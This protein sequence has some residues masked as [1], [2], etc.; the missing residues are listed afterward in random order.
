MKASFKHLFY[1][2]FGRTEFAPFWEFL[3]KTSLR[4]LNYGYCDSPSKS[5]E[6]SVLEFLKTSP[7]A[8]GSNYLLV[9]VGANQ[10][11]YFSF[12]KQHIPNFK[13]KLFEPSI[14][15]YNDLLNTCK[16]EAEIFNLAVGD[17]EGVAELFFDIEGSVQ[18]SLIE[19]PNQQ[20]HPVN[21]ITLDK[22]LGPDIQVD[23][24]VV[25]TEGYEKNVILGAEKLLSEKRIKMI[26]FEHGSQ[27]SI[28]NRTY[29]K[30]FFDILPQYDIFHIKQN[31]IRKFTYKSESEI[32]YNTNYLAV[33][34]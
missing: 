27:H 18:S 6:K 12:F 14:I 7:P 4:G 30:D 24:L 22:A 25:D 15:C 26:Q 20:S 13:A 5:G 34:K 17:K 2:T 23:L 29:I 28:K 21:V 3:Y 16:T 11:Q 10:G 1:K 19:S 32:Y 8:D 31:G 9:D 33:L